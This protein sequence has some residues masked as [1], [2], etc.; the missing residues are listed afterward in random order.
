M[1][2]QANGAQMRAC[3][4]DEAWSMVK[5][6]SKEKFWGIIDRNTVKRFG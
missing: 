4:E 3:A 5:A 6:L 1:L 2:E